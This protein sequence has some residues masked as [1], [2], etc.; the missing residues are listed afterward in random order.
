MG[1]S[2]HAQQPQPSGAATATWTWCRRCSR[3]ATSAA[4]A[5]ASLVRRTW[6]SA[7]APAWTSCAPSAT[8]A[9]VRRARHPAAGV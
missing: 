1:R 6:L 4:G 3:A 7:S 9:H 2:A 5:R 8:N